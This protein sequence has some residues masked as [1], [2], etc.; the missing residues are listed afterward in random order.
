MLQL[1]NNNK[2]PETD[3]PG[4]GAVQYGDEEALGSVEGGEQVSQE[5]RRSRQKHQARGPCDA[6]QKEQCQGANRPRPG[7]TRGSRAGEKSHYIFILT[8]NFNKSSLTW[9]CL[10]AS[11][12]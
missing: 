6:L 11:L 12:I 8:S 7:D 3:L 9:I 4:K 5:E 2:N 1:H 10:N